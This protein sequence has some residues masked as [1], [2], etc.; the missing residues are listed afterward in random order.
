MSPLDDF[1]KN[2]KIF[3][4]TAMSKMCRESMIRTLQGLG[5]PTP[6]Y[7]RTIPWGYVKENNVLMPIEQD[8][9]ILLKACDMADSR[10]Y[11]GDDIVA[12]VKAAPTVSKNFEKRN[13]YYI[14]KNRPPFPELR[15][16]ILERVELVYRTTSRTSEKSI[17]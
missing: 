7:S 10:Q 2:H 1:I 16:P 9:Q 17:A 11:H 6:S 14:R 3:D 8:L 5:L 4:A 15:L 13:F 12:W